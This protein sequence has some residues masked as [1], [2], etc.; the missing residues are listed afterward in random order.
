MRSHFTPASVGKKTMKSH[1]VSG[2]AIVCAVTGALAIM[3][4]SGAAQI[5]FDTATDSTYAGGWSAGQNGGSGFGA[6][7]FNGTSGGSG[8]TMSSAGAIGTAWTLFN[9]SSSSGISDVG[10]S[11]TEAGGL[12]AGQTFEAILQNPTA[13]HF[14]RGFDILFF[15]GTDNYGSGVGSPIA[16]RAQVFDY[17]GSNWKVTDGNGTTTTSL[18]QATTGASGVRLDLALTSATSYIFTLTPL[19]GAGAYSLSGTLGTSVPINYVNFRLYG[20]A[21]TGP[22][23]V[24]DNEGISSMQILPYVVPEPASLALFGLGLGG[25]FFCRRRK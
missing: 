6:W 17:F 21:S 20:T 22:D 23:D 2:T 18:T 13:Y 8:Q 1:F 9:A 3:P 7:N 14:Y 10:R 11:I 12:Q 25:L 15:N 24:T 19:N 4:S 16:L 5:A